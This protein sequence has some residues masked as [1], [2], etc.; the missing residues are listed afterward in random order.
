[1][2]KETVFDR[3]NKALSESMRRTDE[4]DDGERVVYGTGVIFDNEADLYEHITG[5]RSE[6]LDKNDE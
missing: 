1:M 3:M 4:Q 2:S 6:V 5:R